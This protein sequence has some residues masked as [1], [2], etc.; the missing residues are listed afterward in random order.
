[1]GFFYFFNQVRASQQLE[2]KKMTKRLLFCLMEEKITP[3]RQSGI[4]SE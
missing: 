2:Q 1:M 4:E 3:N